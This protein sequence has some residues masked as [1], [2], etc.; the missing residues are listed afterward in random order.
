MPALRLADFDVSRV[1]GK[2][3]HWAV[4]ARDS[5][6]PVHVV[7]YV[8]LAH[9]E[10]R[11]GAR[12]GGSAARRHETG[13]AVAAGHSAAGARVPGRSVLGVQSLRARGAGAHYESV[14]LDVLRADGNTRSARDGGRDLAA[15][16]VGPGRTRQTRSGE[17]DDRGDHRIVLA[18]RRRRVDRDFYGRV[19]DSV[20]G[21]E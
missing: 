5:E 13:Q 7:Q 1:Q 19:P 4:P 11:D 21:K 15:D 12:A 16:A 8:R 9:V 2:K 18:L 17:R 20:R 6:Y 10:S 3:P 14:R